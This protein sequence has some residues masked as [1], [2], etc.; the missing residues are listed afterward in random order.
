MHFSNTLSLYLAKKFLIGLAFTFIILMAIVFLVD[1]VELLRRAAKT[2]SAGFAIA[3]QLA[4]LKLPTLMLKLLP[5]ASLFGAVWTF[6][7]LTRSHELVVARAAGVSAWQFLAPAI[8]LAFGVGVFAIVAF[9]P[10]ASVMVSKY[11]RIE[12]DVLEGRASQ[13]AVSESGLWLRQASDEGQAVIHATN[14]SEG[15]AKLQNVMVFLYKGS[16]TFVARIDADS[17]QLKKKYWQITNAVI[18]RANRKTESLES[19]RLATD[20]SLED[21][22][23]SFAPPET[24]SFWSLP[25]FISALETAGFSAL[26]HR[27]H[28]HGLLALPLLL[29]AMVILAAT[30]TMRQSRRGGTGIMIASGVMA[31]FVLY[32]VSDIVSAFGLAGTLPVALAAWMPAGLSILLGLALMLHLEDG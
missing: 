28:W 17:A 12:S 11:E 6:A 18:T 20:L 15:G 24:L 13:L 5:F 22:H 7:S 1:T 4:A 25:G 32:F 10:V 30:F 29:S 27:L 16:D 3:L 9:N 8:V 14:V 31:A 19:Y 26:R 23:D 2:E 21:I